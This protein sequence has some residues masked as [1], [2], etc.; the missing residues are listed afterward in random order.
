M[1]VE[2]K[3]INLIKPYWRNPRHNEDAVESV[4]ESIEKFGYRVPIVLDK[5]N[6]IITGHTRYLAIRK[7]MGNLNERLKNIPADSDLYQ[8]LAHI[9]NGDVPV[10]Y[11]KDL[12]PED[13][14]EFR[15]ADNKTSE[16]SSWDEDKLI[17]E[18]RELEE[19][20]GFSE[21]EL[22]QLLQIEEDFPEIT[23]EEIEET[24]EQVEGAVTGGEDNFIVITCPHCFEEFEVTRRDVLK[25]KKIES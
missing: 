16:L 5:E 7:L 11:A 23:D 19:C 22:N 2:L 15:I 13:V 17:F 24:Q 18:L 4:M 25:E 3:N 14:A 6:V 9:N 8:N 10:L 12:P 21:D 20:V 1:K